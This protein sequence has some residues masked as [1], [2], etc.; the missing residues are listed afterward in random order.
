MAPKRLRTTLIDNRCLIR[1]W[2]RP[3]R[4]RSFMSI[5]MNGENA[6]GKSMI[7][8]TRVSLLLSSLTR[9]MRRSWRGSMVITWWGSRPTNQ[10]LKLPRK[11]TLGSRRGR[12]LGLP[13]G[14]WS[15]GRVLLRL[16]WECLKVGYTKWKRLFMKA[17][18]G[19]AIPL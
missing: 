13:K 1:K 4:W 19:L 18:L 12:T 5:I 8:W 2:K 14:W 10:R 7:N 16:R 15:V 17:S 9:Y 6:T 3:R 11:R